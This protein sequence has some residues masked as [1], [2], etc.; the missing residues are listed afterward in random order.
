MKQQAVEINT[1]RHGGIVAVPSTLDFSVPEPLVPFS[2]CP[3][4]L[5]RTSFGIAAYLAFVSL[6]PAILHE[7]LMEPRR[8]RN[9]PPRIAPP[10]PMMWQ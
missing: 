7:T 3:K 4:I 2:K 6:I 10:H 9:R 1:I 5:A 8:G